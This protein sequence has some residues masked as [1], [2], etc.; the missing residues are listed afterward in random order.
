MALDAQH[1]TVFKLGTSDWLEYGF[2]KRNT[3][4][5]THTNARAQWD[6]LQA[7]DEPVKVLWKKPASGCKLEKKRPRGWHTLTHVETGGGIKRLSFFH[8]L[9]RIFMS[10]FV[11]KVSKSP[12][13]WESAVSVQTRVMSRIR[14]SSEHAPG[15]PSSWF[16]QLKNMLHY[17]QSCPATSKQKAK[18]SGPIPC[19]TISINL[20]K[21]LKKD[22]WNLLNLLQLHYFQNIN[23]LMACQGKFAPSLSIALCIGDICMAKRHPMCISWLPV[24]LG[25][26]AEAQKCTNLSRTRLKTLPNH[27]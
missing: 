6:R 21:G 19:C 22:L 17:T 20:F 3:H 23:S 26:R 27:R 2:F 14:M 4:T 13:A 25:W 1:A 24:R 18:T 15:A 5:H 9:S 10:H 12:I 7:V 11:L 8:E 16:S